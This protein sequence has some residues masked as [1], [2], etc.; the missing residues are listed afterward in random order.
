[1]PVSETPGVYMATPIVSHDPATLRLSVR[2]SYVKVKQ[3]PLSARPAVYPRARLH[4]IIRLQKPVSRSPAVHIRIT[5][6]VI[7]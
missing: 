1:M 3:R 2:L 7:W 5:C 6:T 4:S